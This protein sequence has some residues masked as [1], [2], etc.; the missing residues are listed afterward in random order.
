MANPLGGSV[1]GGSATIGGTGTANVTVNQS[2][3][4]AVINWNSFNINSGETTQF[5]QPNSSSSVLNR[6]TGDINASQIYG[7]LSANGR[8]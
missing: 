1:A 2:S 7:T 8:V 6:V 3:Q 5:V 4:T